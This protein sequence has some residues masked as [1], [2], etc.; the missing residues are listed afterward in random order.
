[1]VD[2][3]LAFSVAPNGTGSTVRWQSASIVNGTLAS[4]AQGILVPLAKRQIKALVKTCQDR[5]G[6]GMKHF[7]RKEDNRLVRGLGRFVD[8]EGGGSA[9]HCKLVR[10]PYAHAKIL[11][12]DTSAAEAMDGVV[13][14]LV[15]SEVAAQTTKFIQ[16]APPPAANV[17]DYCMATDRVRFQGEPVAAVV[18][19]TPAIAADAVELVRVDYEPLPVVTDAVESLKDEVILHEA[20]GTNKT[21]GSVFDWGEVDKAFAQ[22]DVVVEIDRLKFHRF[23]STPLENYAVLAN[24]EASGRLDVLS[25]HHSARRRDEIHGA[26]VAA[27][28]RASPHPHPG[29]RRRLRH[30]AEYLS[31]SDDRGAVLAQGRT[32]A[33]EM[34]RGAA[35]ASAGQR[36]WQRA[37]VSRHQG[38]AQ[39]GRRDHRGQCAPC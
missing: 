31:L 28:D 37:H 16:M 34:D 32:Q 27:F 15:G 38:C 39:E 21:W 33:G 24:W 20:S 17:V 30:Q 35:R 11:N 36:A 10:S 6:A 5:L 1:M 8:D 13:C 14:T 19:R 26:G 3:E 12:I 23:S 9:L 7:A 29:H 25:Q 18:A 22:A 4:L 2:S